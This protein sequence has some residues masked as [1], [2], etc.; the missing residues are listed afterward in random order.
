MSNFFLTDHKDREKTEEYLDSNPSFLVD[1][2]DRNMELLDKYVVDKIDEA[3][4]QKW[5]TKVAGPIPS[6]CGTRM[7][8]I[9][10][11]QFNFTK[12]LFEV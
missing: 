2:I 7:K 3:T 4:I 11:L 6:K 1:Y 5:L 10:W 9:K 12:V 8:T